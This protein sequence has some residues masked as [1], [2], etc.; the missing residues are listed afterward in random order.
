MLILSGILVESNTTQFANY[1]SIR[2]NS[3]KKSM[4]GNRLNLFVT[5]TLALFF[6]VT[7]AL[8]LPVETVSFVMLLCSVLSLAGLAS[9]FNR[10]KVSKAFPVG[11]LIVIGCISLSSLFTSSQLL[12]F[13]V[14][15][16][17]Y[18][19]ALILT[20]YFASESKADA[21][22]FS[23][24]LRYITWLSTIVVLLSFYQRVTITWP[25]LD[26]LATSISGTSVA[27]GGR[28][29]GTMGH[30]IIFGAVAVLGVILSMIQMRKLWTLTF[31]ICLAGVVNSG[32]RSAFLAVGVGIMA[33]LLS[34]K[35]TRFLSASKFVKTFFASAAVVPLVALSPLAPI[36]FDSVFQ[37]LNIFGDAS[38]TA[39]NIRGEI[40]A[41]RIFE[42]PEAL[43]V[44][45]GALADT[46]YITTFGLR[47][48][49]AATFDNF[50]LSVVHNFGLIT[51]VPLI[52]LM[53]IFL[54]MGSNESRALFLV[55]ASFLFFVDITGWPTLIALG[56]LTAGLS[57]VSS[58]SAPA[59][60]AFLHVPL[61][62]RVSTS[63]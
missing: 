3:R 51:L 52:V 1:Q 26:D 36:V 32:S 6:P 58:S 59:R 23:G 18:G 2:Q 7:I 39:R 5:A 25:I 50:Y 60:R 57:Q 63:L 44:G 13:F 42:S 53:L 45:H 16:R 10:Q 61:K 54:R 12:D 24:L 46:K 9:R 55:F 48:S 43:L 21:I 37:R 11:I 17:P 22:G 15:L 56:A 40:A 27:F 34:E 4:T 35:R 20:W 14:A 41:A 30:P 33:L 31:F 38:G 19:F 8:G 47:D 28:P 49:E 62:F 29:G